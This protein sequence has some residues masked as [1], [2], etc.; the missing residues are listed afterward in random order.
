VHVRLVVSWWEALRRGRFRLPTPW[1]PVETELPASVA[2]GGAELKI[3]DHGARPKGRPWGR[4]VA[5]VELLAPAACQLM[6]LY[7]EAAQAALQP[8]AELEKLLKHDAATAVEGWT[9]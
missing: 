7:L 6:L 9:W 1:G 2:A 3:D 5:H 4:L 8:R